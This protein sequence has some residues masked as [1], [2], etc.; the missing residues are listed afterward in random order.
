MSA[1]PEKNKPE[2]LYDATL[3]QDEELQ[4]GQVVRHKLFGYRGVIIDAHPCYRGSDEWY[5]EQAPSRP[6]RD[7]PWYEVLVHGQAHQTYVAKRNLEPDHS[8]LP[9]QHPLIRMFFGEFR[10]GRYSVGGPVN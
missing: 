6:P 8:G 9:V 3:S 2:V 1:N 10:N 4:V 7:E 5:E